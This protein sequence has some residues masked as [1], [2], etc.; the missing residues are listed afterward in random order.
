MA[1]GGGLDET[2][3]RDLASQIVDLINDSRKSRDEQPFR[4]YAWLEIECKA[5]ASVAHKLQCHSLFVERDDDPFE[6]HSNIKGFPPPS[7]DEVRMAIATA[8][9]AE[10]WFQQVDK[11]GQI[12]GIRTKN[13]E[14]GG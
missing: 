12:K 13:S 8:L 14:V 1:D 3:K 9:S 4:L 2:G 7:Q 10:C 11:Q 5:V 6:R